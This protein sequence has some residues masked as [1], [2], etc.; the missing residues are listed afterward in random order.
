MLVEAPMLVK[1]LFGAAVLLVFS[2]LIYLVL[3]LALE[4]GR[5]SDL[6]GRRPGDKGWKGPGRF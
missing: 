1:L 3:W 6:A 4:S 5:G 2:P